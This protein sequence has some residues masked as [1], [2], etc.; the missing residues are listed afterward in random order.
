MS[1]VVVIPSRYAASRLPGKPLREIAGRPMIAHV[2]DRGR[3]SGAT[4]VIVATDDQRIADA[5]SKEGA[6]AV[7][8][9][10]DHASGTDRIAEV[11]RAREWSEDTIVVNL[12]GDEPCIEP[13]LL[14]MVAQALRTCEDA[15]MSTVATPIR[16]AAELFDESVVK[17]VLDERCMARYFSRAPIPW[18]RGVF[19][20]GPPATLPDG[21][22]FLRHVGLYGY[23]VG[24]LLR[25]AQGEPVAAERAESLEQL[26][27]L[28]MGIG[29]HVSV[30]PESPGPGVDTEEDLERAKAALEK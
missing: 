20:Q 6:Q 28:A 26:R 17:V 1:F 9:S 14:A 23:R 30:V 19:S 25:V 2:V 12:Q 5:V 3:E 10:P 13:S 27:A 7:M 21:V 11:A 15:G 18:V 4:E 16:S 24:D 22:P 8:T 29:I